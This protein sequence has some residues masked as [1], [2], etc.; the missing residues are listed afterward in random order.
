MEV[1]YLILL[2][3]VVVIVLYIPLGI[4]NIVIF[5][6]ERGLLF[7][8]GK[9]ERVL[10]PGRHRYSH[11]SMSIQK[12]GIRSRMVTLPGQEVL[13]ADNVGIKVSMVC[14][15]KVDD[16][17]RAFVAVENYA[18]VIYAELQVALR[19][20]VGETPIEEFLTKRAEIGEALLE[21]TQTK[22]SAYGIL[23]ESVAVKDIMFPGELKRI[24]AQV[25]NAKMEGLAALERARGE[26]AAL[27]NLANTA[28]LLEK[29]PGLLQLRILQTIEKN[30]ATIVILGDISKETSF[31]QL[32]QGK[33]NKQ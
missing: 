2:A 21:R 32:T 1:F 3:V 13:S 14:Q 19:N 31:K 33:T 25:V 8:N 30:P 16:P 29:N 24:F 18:Q 4:R 20:L 26:S 10:G 17:Y 5:E 9:F 27:R 12:V 15:Y 6:Y 7:K 23:L 28:N 11:W 22:A